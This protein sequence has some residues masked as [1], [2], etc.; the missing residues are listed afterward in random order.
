MCTPILIASAALAVGSAASNAIAHN[1]QSRARNDVLAAERVRQSH[2]NAQADAVNTG[3]RER[4]VDFVP[5]MEDKSARLGDELA[6]RVAPDPNS[7]AGTIMPSS[8]SSIVNQEIE[9][10]RG[11]A[12]AY[13]DQQGG[14]MADMRSF[15][16]LLGNISTH[17]ARD[18]GKIAQIGGFKQGSNNI[19]PLELTEAAKAGDGWLL[20]GDILGGLGSIGATAGINGANP[21]ASLFAPKPGAVGASM[22][23]GVVPLNPSLMA[24]GV[25]L[26]VT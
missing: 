2:F 12:Q 15:G 3:A 9:A 4:Y 23:G 18:A 1:A 13:V 22:A 24:G 11:K 25:G 21:L 26:G 8:D 10:Q 20:L 17:Q 19:M 16:D 7:T 6:A 14:A 5:H